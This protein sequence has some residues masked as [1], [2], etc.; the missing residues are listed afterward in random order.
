[1]EEDAAARYARYLRLGS[2]VRGGTIEPHWMPDGDSFWYAEPEPDGLAV[3]LIDAEGD[4]RPLFNEP[5]LRAALEEHLGR[6]LTGAGVPFS[7]FTVSEDGSRVAFELEGRRLTVDLDEYR[8]DEPAFRFREDERVWDKPRLVRRPLQTGEAD[9][10]ES[11]SPDGRW[12]VGEDSHNLTVRGAIDGRVRALTT[13]GTEDEPWDVATVLWSPDSARILAARID[14]RSVDRLPIVHWLQPSE[15]IEWMWY[16]R[17]GGAMPQISLR[18]VDIRSGRQT[19]VDTGPELDQMLFPHSWASDGSS[20]LILKL[21]RTMKPATLLRV[22]AG[23]GQSTVLLHEE[24][25]TY[26]PQSNLDEP[27]QG[28]VTPLKDG[29]FLWL[30]D[31]TGWSHVYLYDRDGTLIRPLTSGSFPVLAVVAVDEERGSVYVAANAEDRLYDTH[32]YRL[33]LEGQGF[34][35][36]TEGEGVHS[37]ALSPSRRTFLDTWSSPTQPPVVELRAA[38]GRRL[39]TL[40]QANISALEEV[41]WRPPEEFVVPAADGE[42]PLYGLL[43]LPADFDPLGSYPV[44]EY[45]YGGPQVLAVP[46]TFERR[47]GY[48]ALPRALAELGFAIVMVD[49]RGTL[50]R[51]REF[52]GYSYGHFGETV[53]RDHVAALRAL[54]AERPYLDLERVGIFGHSWGGYNTLRAMLLAPDLFRVGVAAAPV[55]DLEDHYGEWAEGVMGLITENPEG[56]AAASNLTVAGNLQGRLLLIHGTSDANATLSATLK[57]ADALARAGRPFDLLILPEQNHHPS[58]EHEPF[59]ID[60]I[61]RY[62]QEHL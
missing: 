52:H 45:I 54:A 39:T 23:T 49:G 27:Q 61:R 26:L 42:T 36:L 25:E 20:I 34:T 62:F 4:R 5:R 47:S 57:M 44:V 21:G 38:D 59:W 11:P 7:D 19:L 28:I 50:G 51:S 40:S 35:R 56:Y 16:P 17:T 13:G 14:Y 2:L 29:R 53:V 1:M 24:I 18:V 3:Y 32:I 60:Q 9:V 31:R 55:A 8:V 10:W 15:T 41:G 33:D 48:R 37:A 6:P 43:Y 58:G 46:H 30:S 22:D 12:I